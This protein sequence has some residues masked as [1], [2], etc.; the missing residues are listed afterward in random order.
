MYPLN[1]SLPNSL[2]IARTVACSPDRTRS[3]P[4]TAA[5]PSPRRGVI[6]ATTQADAGEHQRVESGT[7]HRAQV[8][9]QLLAERQLGQQ[10]TGEQQRERQPISRK[11]AAAMPAYF[12]WT[13]CW[14]LSGREK[15]S[16]A[17]RNRRS[18]DITA[19]AW[20]PRK[21]VTATWR[22]TTYSV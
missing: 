20:E 9:R 13:Y 5:T 10:R 7:G 8:V 16:G 1:V 4:T 14:R 6:A 17:T 21:I 2:A 11:S 19:G 3:T 15:Y 18:R 22:V 12:A